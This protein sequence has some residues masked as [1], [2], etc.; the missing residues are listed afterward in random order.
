MTVCLDIKEK[1]EV[2]VL[3]PDKSLGWQTLICLKLLPKLLGGFIFNILSLLFVLN[4]VPGS[5]S[6]WP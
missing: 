2:S 6:T 5:D 4:L 3:A 1:I